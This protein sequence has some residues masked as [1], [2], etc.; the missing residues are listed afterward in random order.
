[1]ARSPARPRFYTPLRNLVI[2]SVVS[3]YAV[4]I[5]A[6]AIAVGSKGFCKVPD[7]PYSFKDSCIPFY[8]M[9]ENLLNYILEEGQIKILV[10]LADGRTSK[11]SK[12]EVKPQVIRLYW[13]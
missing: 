9:F 8:R 2:M 11:M 5:K 1:M 13:L 6:D 4:T 10:P 7:D 12:K 3:V